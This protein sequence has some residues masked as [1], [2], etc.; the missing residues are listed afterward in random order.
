MLTFT[1]ETWLIIRLLS[2]WRVASESASTLLEQIGALLVEWYPDTNKVF[3]RKKNVDTVLQ[4]MVHIR[5]LVTECPP[6]RI[7]SLLS[8]LAD[9]LAV[10]VGDEKQRVPVQKYN[11]IVSLFKSL[12]PSIP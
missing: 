3:D 4:V 2:R 10:W 5:T 1:R 9:G 11:D 6:A 8:P 7:L 12:Y